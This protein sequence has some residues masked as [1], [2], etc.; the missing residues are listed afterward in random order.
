MVHVSFTVP[1]RKIFNLYTHDTTV[2]RV[3]DRLA[4]DVRAPQLHDRLGPRG[5]HMLEVAQV[6]VVGG[7]DVRKGVEVLFADLTRLVLYRDVVL[8]KE[9]SRPHHGPG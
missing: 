3:R 4:V 1:T 5:A 6:G 8:F 7:E 9:C 2:V